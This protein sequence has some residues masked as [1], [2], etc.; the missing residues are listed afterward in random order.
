[1]TEFNF[2]YRQELKQLFIFL[3][4]GYYCISCSQPP[5]LSLDG[6]LLQDTQEKI[7]KWQK[8]GRKV[9][10]LQTV[11]QVEQTERRN[12]SNTNKFGFSSSEL[13]ILV[14]KSNRSHKC[15]ETRS[16]EDENSKRK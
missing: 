6:M 10:N 15:D 13:L 16:I 7:Q 8:S 2:G 12:S 1:M 5:S 3:R 9:P 14:F 4:V 11:L